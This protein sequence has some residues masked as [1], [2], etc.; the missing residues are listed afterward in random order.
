M[1]RC[2]PIDAVSLSSSCLIFSISVSS[3]QFYIY[4]VVAGG[5]IKGPRSLDLA[6]DIARIPVGVL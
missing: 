1:D 2:K 3:I 5:A 4:I 6:A